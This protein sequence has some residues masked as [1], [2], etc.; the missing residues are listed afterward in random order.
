MILMHGDDKGII[1][2]PRVAPLQLVMVPIYYK[3]EEKEKVLAKLNEIDSVLQGLGVRTRIDDRTIYTPGWKFNHWEVK[4]VPIRIEIGMKDYVASTVTVVRRDTGEK[5]RVSW[6][7]VKTE[8][9]ALLEQI[10]NDMLQ[11]AK[12]NMNE[13]I[14]KATNWEQF[15]SSINQRKSCLS[16]W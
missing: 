9:P 4:G 8:I 15:M 5:K 10:Q 1:M 12:K 2:P 6:E 7:N 14:I 11:N 16:P 3:P 13:C